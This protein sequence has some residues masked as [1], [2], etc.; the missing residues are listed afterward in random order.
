MQVPTLRKSVRFRARRFPWNTVISAVPASGPGAELR[1][2]HVRRQ[3]RVFRRLG[4]HRCRR[5]QRLVDICL[6][7]G[8]N[9]FDTADI[10][11][12]GASERSSARRSRAGATRCSSRPRRRSARRRPER[13][14]L[15]AL[16]SDRRRS[17]RAL[18]RLR[19]RLHRP[20]PAARLRREDAGRR[21]RSRRS[22]ISCAPARSAI[23][24]SRISPAGI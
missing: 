3:G 12:N 17:T 13:C 19:H 23:S 16:S 14:R 10:Y 4:H 6:D 22:T 24:A 2:R 1:H 8:V 9:M 20:L 7:A 18:K 11:S 15:V 21:S 5:R